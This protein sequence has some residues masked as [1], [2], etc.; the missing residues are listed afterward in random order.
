MRWQYAESRAARADSFPGPTAHG[1]VL[2]RKRWLQNPGMQAVSKAKPMGAD[3]GW[4]HQGTRGLPRSGSG[5]GSP[6]KE[7]LQR[8]TSK[9]ESLPPTAISEG[10]GWGP[11]QA[12]QPHSFV[13]T[14]SALVKQERGMANSGEKPHTPRI[15]IMET[16][17]DT[18]G[19]RVEVMALKFL[20]NYAIMRRCGFKEEKKKKVRGGKTTEFQDS[21]FY[22]F[23][24][25]SAP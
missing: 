3:G 17:A 21:C 7:V 5:G 13:P 11:G 19:N 6:P 15:A 4:G 16:A 1:S 14:P 12:R 2:A 18:A 25:T 20:W 24:V 23:Q 9:W 22:P 8:Y 10:G